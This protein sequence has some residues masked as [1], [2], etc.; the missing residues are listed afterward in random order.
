[1]AQKS[2]FM[3]NTQNKPEK[4]TWIGLAHV[5]PWPGNNMLEG[6]IGAFV[7]VLALAVDTSDFISVATDRLNDYEFYVVG[8]EDVQ[9]F[10]ERLE[11][12]EK[13]PD[14]CYV[15]SEIVELAACLSVDEPVSLST[16]DAYENE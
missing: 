2:E 16:F 11:E 7:N 15:D 1:M 14:G 10:E 3:M 6:A 5:K 4:R 8:I 9:V 13:R 12:C